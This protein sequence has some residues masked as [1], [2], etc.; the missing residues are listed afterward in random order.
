MKNGNFFIVEPLGPLL[1]VIV[2][3]IF[4]ITL[5]HWVYVILPLSV[6]LRR[7]RYGLFKKLPSRL[8]G[9]A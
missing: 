2:L 6:R 4:G 5:N 1:A 9:M 3:A 7:Q 8:V